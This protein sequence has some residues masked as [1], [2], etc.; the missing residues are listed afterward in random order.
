MCV[1]EWISLEANQGLMK[2][3]GGGVMVLKMNSK[4]TPSVAMH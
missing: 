2:G 3:G 1:W 4:G